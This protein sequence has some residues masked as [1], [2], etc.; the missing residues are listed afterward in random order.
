MDPYTATIRGC[1]F[2]EGVNACSNPSRGRSAIRTSQLPESAANQLKGCTSV[3]HYMDI[4]S[5][6]CDLLGEIQEGSIPEEQKE[7]IFSNRRQE[8]LAQQVYSRAQRR[9]WRLLSDAAPLPRL[10]NAPASCCNSSRSQMDKEAS[11]AYRH[12]ISFPDCSSRVCL[13]CS[14][15]TPAVDRHAGEL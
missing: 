5:E 10:D 7:K 13:A 12:M 14:C 1:R 6:G 3:R 15:N 8:L 2:S 9:L 11:R 4:L